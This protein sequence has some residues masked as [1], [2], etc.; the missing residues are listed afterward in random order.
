MAPSGPGGRPRNSW[1]S[2]R[3]RKLIRLYTMTNL[4]I[5]E[6][7]KV[8]ET[9]GFN[10]R[11][12]DIQKKLKSLFSTDY[13][14][15]YRSYRPKDYENTIARAAIFSMSHGHRVSKA[16]RYFPMRHSS[17]FASHCTQSNA[18]Q[19]SSQQETPFPDDTDPQSGKSLHHLPS[20]K[21]TDSWQ[22][23]LGGPSD[24][25]PSAYMSPPETFEIGVA[26][27]GRFYRKRDAAVLDLG[28]RRKGK[29]PAGNR[30]PSR[31][32]AGCSQTDHPTGAIGYIDPQ[33]LHFMHTTRSGD[34]LC[35]STLNH[36]NQF[37]I[38]SADPPSPLKK[39]LSPPNPFGTRKAIVDK[40]Y[41]SAPK[42]IGCTAGQ[43]LVNA[44]SLPVEEPHL[45]MIQ[46]AL[47]PPDL[48]SRPFVPGNSKWPISKYDISAP[49]LTSSP[50]TIETF[51]LPIQ[52]FSK[53]QKLSTPEIPL[54]KLLGPGSRTFGL[55]PRRHSDLNSINI[56]SQPPPLMSAASGHQSTQH[57][58]QHLKSQLRDR[59]PSYV[60]HV[61]TVLRLSSTGSFRSSLSTSTGRS[62]WMSFRSGLSRNSK[63][64][65]VMQISPPVLS[66][67]Q[68]HSTSPNWQSRP[69]AAAMNRLQDVEE[70]IWHELIDESKL[71]P[72]DFRPH[73]R[74]I[75]LSSRPCCGLADNI[76]YPCSICGFCPIHAWARR[77]EVAL[78]G[79]ARCAQTIKER[80]YFGNTPLHF[81]A[82]SGNASPAFISTLIEYGADPPAKNSSHQTF[83]HVLSIIGPP[84][85]MMESKDL[86][87]YE[88]LLLQLREMG[89]NLMDR[90][91]HGWTAAHVVARDLCLKLLQLDIINIVMLMPLD[92]HG[93]IPGN[94]APGIGKNGKLYNQGNIDAPP[95]TVTSVYNNLDCYRTAI[96]EC[97]SKWEYESDI[98]V[99]DICGNTPLIAL[100]NKWTHDDGP[101]STL[102]ETLRLLINIGANVDMRDRKGYTALAISVIR[103]SRPCTLTLLDAGACPN[104]RTY[105]GKGIVHQVKRRMSV[106]KCEGHD[107]T[108]ARILSCVNLL[109]DRG[110]KLEPTERDEWLFNSNSHTSV[111]YDYVMNGE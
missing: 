33:K 100:M 91:Y 51:D 9:E 65:H 74:E 26:V 34:S 54:N 48:Q 108:W 68:G 60:Q 66:D 79:F 99:F 25:K 50:P 61:F 87:G 82:A 6:I 4:S 47:L 2:S 8:L 89:F 76:E 29:R 17:K 12:R 43:S 42:L 97:K 7:Q 88:A 110:A 41:I 19:P 44:I 10:P 53:S 75:S 67:Q 90:D 78:H 111:D 39:D 104:S 1:T 14:K 22:L 55:V 59:T 105:S 86:A 49:E 56:N 101:E 96:V 46:N 63:S 92:N 83:L 27:T 98:N 103:G 72:V 94:P 18:H 95:H 58:E 20:S 77:G 36:Y 57:M 45:S 37:P 73:Y 69:S 52:E 21:P 106:A 71:I 35:P 15:Q 30:L 93:Y 85:L 13:T 102:N 23:I 62:S 38:D 84:S 28:V 81:A 32:A 3:R 40:E 64:S 5:A 70:D 11:A 107:K 109:A 31:G 80:D 16:N 24:S